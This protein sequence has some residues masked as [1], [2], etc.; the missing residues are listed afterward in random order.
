MLDMPSASR[1][2]TTRGGSSD[3]K[4]APNLWEAS[5]FIMA[6]PVGIQKQPSAHDPHPKYTNQSKIMNRTVT[7]LAL[8]PPGK[9][10]LTFDGG[11]RPS[12]FSTAT[13]FWLVDL[14]WSHDRC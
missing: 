10:S 7:T 13:V 9:K 8:A 1:L 11:A 5:N 4:L 12:C 2:S 3:K 6:A 14:R